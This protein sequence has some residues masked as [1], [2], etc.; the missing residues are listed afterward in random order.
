MISLILERV[1][2]NR[3][4]IGNIIDFCGCCDRPRIG[5]ISDF[6][7]CVLKFLE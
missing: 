4:R 2:S 6:R 1:C 7:A 5:D 3:H